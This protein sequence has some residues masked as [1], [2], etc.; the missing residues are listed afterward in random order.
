MAVD[1]EHFGDFNEVKFNITLNLTDDFKDHSSKVFSVAGNPWKIK[2]QRIKGDL[3]VHLRSETKQ[4]SNDWVIVASFAIEIN[5]QFGPKFLK[6]FMPFP[7]SSKSSEWGSNALIPWQILMASAN[8]YVRANK[9]KTVVSANS[10]P[11]Q[12]QKGFLDL[13]PVEKC[14]DESSIRFIHVENEQDI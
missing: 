13:T 3:A 1:L 2:F 14:C 5:K 12:R 4:E 9:C 6:K 8:G 11:I 10:M 7:F